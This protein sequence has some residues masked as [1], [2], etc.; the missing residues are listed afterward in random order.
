[1]IPPGI[2]V[3]HPSKN[4]PIANGIVSLKTKSQTGIKGSK[5][6]GCATITI[7]VKK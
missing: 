4:R 1:M 6:N 5:E 7:L 2:D 3:A